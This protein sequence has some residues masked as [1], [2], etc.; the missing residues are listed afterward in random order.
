MTTKTEV[1]TKTWTRP[2]LEVLGKLEDVAGPG[3]IGLEGGP[4]GK[5]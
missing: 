1:V 3:G 5:S 4:N 2:Q